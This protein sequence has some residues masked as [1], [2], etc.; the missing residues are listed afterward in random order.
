MTE[1]I[2][3]V[4]HACTAGITM[5]L[6]QHCTDGAAGAAVVRQSNAVLFFKL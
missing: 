4:I 6:Q 1:L 3:L 2:Q 5:Q